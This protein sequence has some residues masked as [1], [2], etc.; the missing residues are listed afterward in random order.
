MKQRPGEEEEGWKKED[1]KMEEGERGT[2]IH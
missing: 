1:E 2:L